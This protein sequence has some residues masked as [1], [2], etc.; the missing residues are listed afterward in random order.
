MSLTS[1]AGIYLHVPVCVRK[2]PYCSFFS[3]KAR[4]GEITTYLKA[5]MTHLELLTRD[6][7]LH[8]LRF[9]TI[10]F[11]GGTPSLLSA[12]TL[13]QLLAACRRFFPFSTKI[14]EVSIEVNPGT[15]DAADLHLLRKA[16]FNRL[17]IGVQS[18]CDVELQKIGRIHSAQE[19]NNIF[20]EARKAGFD[21]ISIDLM[22]GLPG[23]KIESWTTTLKKTLALQP[24][25]LSLYEL[26]P[27]EPSEFDTRLKQGEVTLPSEETVLAMMEAIDE[28]VI[29]QGLP[30]Y[31]ISSYAAPDS[32]C[33]HNLNYW[34]NGFYVGL[35][36][37]AVSAYGGCRRANPSNLALYSSRVMRQE[38]IW[39]DEEQLT[40]EEAFRETV[41]M[42]LRMIAGISAASLL[43]RFGFYLG[44]YYADV[45]PELLAAQLI[46]W[47]GESLSL[48]PKGFS[49]ANQVMAK[50]V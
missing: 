48:T 46:N 29:P 9:Q 12:E 16:G 21:N 3:A 4:P 39:C 5:V 38:Q 17:S 49:L 41:V 11:G 26:T 30:R 2:C 42:G 20:L 23:Q 34:H 25:H 1:R 24:D 13:G 28:L 33:H 10:F 44:E 50:L 40:R 19:A 14:P 32:Q 7:L 27:E 22:Y 36:P 31:E 15:L 43:V 37:G 8:D 47:N 35:G 45:L 6:P 18:F